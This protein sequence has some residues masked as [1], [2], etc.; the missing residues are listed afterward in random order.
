MDGSLGAI[1]NVMFS[2]GDSGQQHCDWGLGKGY[3]VEEAAAAGK[4]KSP[5]AAVLVPSHLFVLPLFDPI[6]C[7]QCDSSMYLRRHLKT[8]ICY[9]LRAWRSNLLQLLEAAKAGEQLQ[10]SSLRSLEETQFTRS[11][12]PFLPPTS[13]C[14]HSI[15]FDEM[16]E[17]SQLVSWPG[18]LEVQS[19][20]AAAGKSLPSCDCGRLNQQRAGCDIREVGWNYIKLEQNRERFMTLDMNTR[21]II[22]DGT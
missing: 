20:T 7:N 14:N 4:L 18:G 10:W 5:A 3:E 2:F 21:L 1:D 6:K 17:N 8:H 19:G 12:G 9:D 13:R 16:F 11:P 15:K 22:F